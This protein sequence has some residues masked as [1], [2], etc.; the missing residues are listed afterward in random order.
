MQERCMW[1]IYQFIA[2]PFSVVDT[3]TATMKRRVKDFLITTFS[4][5]HSIVEITLVVDFEFAL[6]FSIVS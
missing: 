3:L 6:N 4:L 2:D 1:K 5:S